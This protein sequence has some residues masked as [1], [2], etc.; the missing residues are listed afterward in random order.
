MGGVGGGGTCSSIRLEMLWKEIIYSYFNHYDAWKNRTLEYIVL[1]RHYC[2]CCCYNLFS[3]IDIS[4]SLVKII[5]VV[6]SFYT[7]IFW[8]ARSH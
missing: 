4:V 1:K 6:T 3:A 5:Q 2:V 8:Y 7:Y